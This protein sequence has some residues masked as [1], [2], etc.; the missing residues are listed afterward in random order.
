MSGRNSPSPAA[1][2]TSSAPRQPRPRAARITPAVAGTAMGRQPRG[3]YAAESAMPEANPPM[4]GH[5]A[6]PRTLGKPRLRTPDPPNGSEAS[7]TAG[8]SGASVLRLL[9]ATAPRCSRSN[10]QLLCG[11][12]PSSHGTTAKHG[13]PVRARPGANG[14]GE[15]GHEIG[16]G[17]G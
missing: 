13:A 11:S 5:P 12:Q 1:K 17:P 6:Q 16:Q 4:T 3:G 10:A 14:G 9:P 7:A 8:V 2:P 15:I